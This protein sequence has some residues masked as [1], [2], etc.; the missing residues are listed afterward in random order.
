MGLYWAEDFGPQMELRWLFLGSAP[1]PKDFG[2]PNPQI[3]GSKL[4]TEPETSKPEIRGYPHQTRSAAIL[5]CGW[6]A[7]AE[8]VLHGPTCWRARG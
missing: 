4:K 2:Y 5:S 3:R 7:A 8:V 6:R 1:N